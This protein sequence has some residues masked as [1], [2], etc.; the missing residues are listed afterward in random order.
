M[1]ELGDDAV[2]ER[3]LVEA[4]L[5]VAREVLEGKDGEGGLA[6]TSPG[7]GT[8]GSAVRE[9]SRSCL[10]GGDAQPAE[11][12]PQGA[13]EEPGGARPLEGHEGGRGLGRNHP[14]LAGEPAHERLQLVAQRGH[15]LVAVPGILGE[16]AIENGLQRGR[17]LRVQVTDRA[18][19]AVDDRA[20]DLHRMLAAERGKPGDHLVEDDAQAEDVRPVVRVLAPRLLRRAVAHRA[21]GH[22]HLRERIVGGGA[23]GRALLDRL[24]HHHLGQAEV[25]DLG[26]ASR[27]H[28][29]VGR[30]QVAMG[31]ATGVGDG[32]GVR[33]LDCDR[34]RGK[35]LQGAA[36]HELLEGRALHVLQ[37]DVVEPVRL[38]DVV[39]RLDVG[40]V[41][42]G[43]QAGLALE[44]A[45]G[46]LAGRQL[47]PQ[48]LDDNGPVEAHVLGLEG[49]GLTAVTQGIED[50]VV[51]DRRAGGELRHRPRLL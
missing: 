22:P 9:R 24:R 12:A 40:I 5:G 36:A 30:L 13:G 42:D 45:A 35:G 50:P 37:D 18:G 17:R 48:G 34:E 10:A 28:D 4:G 49:R 32:E 33:E 51:G 25:E 44:A 26:L 19:R 43:A 16:G 39:D 6:F 46:D 1:G 29:H 2:R 41:E 20:Q 7:R 15:G 23:R 47:G 38:S 11:H 14:G 8:G 21:V 27:G 3:E 31:D